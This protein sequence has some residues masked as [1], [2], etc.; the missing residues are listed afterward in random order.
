MRFAWLPVLCAAAGAAGCGSLETGAAWTEGGA[1]E[2]ISEAPGA[3]MP[4][5]SMPA[6]ALTAGALLGNRDLIRFL[7]VNP[8][9]HTLL[10]DYSSSHPLNA[11]ARSLLEY[12]VGCALD[13][14]QRVLDWE[15]ELGLCGTGAVAPFVDWSMEAPNTACQQI[16]TACVLARVNARGKRVRL[17]TRSYDDGPL[18]PLLPEVPVEKE[19][20]DP[21]GPVLKSFDP[22]CPSGIAPGNPARDCGWSGRRVGTCKAGERVEVRPRRSGGDSF[23]VRVCKGIHGCDHSMVPPPWYSGV[24]AQGV[25]GNDAKTLSFKC[26][27]FGAHSASSFAIMVASPAP[28]SSPPE[29]AD[30][31]ASGVA[32]EYPAP[33]AKVFTFREGAFYGDLFGP[34][35][36]APA[37]EMLSNRQ[38]ACYSDRWTSPMAHLADRLCA[39]G[40]D[41]FGNTP[42]ACIESPAAPPERAKLCAGARDHDEDDAEAEDGDERDGSYYGCVGLPKGA[43]WDPEAGSWY[44]EGA[45]WNHAITVFLNHPCDL[46]GD[47]FK[48]LASGP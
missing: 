5:N 32:V 40:E 28:K 25:L 47:P 21:N 2:P 15:G 12:T 13:P 30:V 39:G 44:P 8:L 14:G 48:C 35:N 17:S 19:H 36:P 16:V 11:N 7:S 27:D 4:R 43:R 10:K 3:M 41:C 9:D 24:L 45:R 33:E 34:I 18:F 31:T 26:P 42:G 38:F 20:R 1:P 22:T 37:G 23:M 6:E 46:A 29:T